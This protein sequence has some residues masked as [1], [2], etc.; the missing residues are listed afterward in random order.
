MS[1][2]RKASAYPEPT[3]YYLPRD[4]EL[5]ARGCRLP[6]S[7]STIWKLLTRLGLIVT[8][9]PIKHS[10]EPLRDPLEEVQV[11]FKDVSSVRPDPSGEGKQQHVV[12]VC[13]FVSVVTPAA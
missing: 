2:S 8:E 6:R 13:N 9:A 10:E 11:D 7:T 5:Q 12:K 3:L 4:A 1:I